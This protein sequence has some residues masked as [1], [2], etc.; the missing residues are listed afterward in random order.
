MP[1][2]DQFAQCE[3]KG[4][5]SAGDGSRARATICL[6]HVAV[7][8]DGPFAKRFQVHDA[9]Q[10]AADEALN[11]VR[12]TADLA[13]FALARGAGEGGPGKHAVLG[14]DPALAAATQ[15]AG[16]RLLDGGVAEHASVAEFNQDRTFG[17]GDEVGCET[18]GAEGIGFPVAAAKDRIVR[19]SA[20]YM[21]WVA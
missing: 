7:Q 6:Q 21:D 11:L 8:N 2:A 16:N 9:A 14:G 15:P 20:E 5:G 4:R 17:S 12:T 18:D 10:G 19:H 3:G 13:A 1:A